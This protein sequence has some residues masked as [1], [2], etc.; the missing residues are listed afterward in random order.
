VGADTGLPVESRLASFEGATG[1]LNSDPLTPAGL[2]GKVIVVDFCTYTCINWLRTLPY[3][4]AWS[5]RYGDRGLTVIGVHTPEFSFERDVD[6][7]RRALRE[8][9]VE[10][11]IAIDSNYG[12]WNA[13]ANHYWPA[14]Y[15]ADAEG[16]IRFHWFGEGEYE[17]SEGVIQDLLRDAGADVP[18]RD[19]VSV[20]GTG[21]EMEADWENLRTPE[22]Y[23]GYQRSQNFSSPGGPVPDQRHTYAVPDRLGV[24]EWALSGEWTL[25]GESAV[26]EVAGARVAFRFHARDLHMIMGPGDR[27]AEVKFRVLL[28]GEPPGDAAGSD[29]DPSGAATLDFPRMYQLIRQPEPIGPRVFEIEFESPGAQAFCFTFG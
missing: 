19:F 15:I 23:V 6:H 2:R 3:V 7:I 21:P 28:D 5:E 4:R 26:V 1:W 18:D 10:H 16:R 12:V 11:P 29:L 17:R 27:D 9:R 20:R 8:M 25:G 13:F 24:N 14:L 22:T